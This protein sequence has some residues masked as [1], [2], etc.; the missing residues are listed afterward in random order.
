[1]VDNI[2]I[3]PA[4]GGSKRIPK[5]NIVDF[6]GKPM[7]AWTIEAAKKTGLFKRI[8]VST[9]NEE[10]ADVSV[11]Y[12]AEVPFF[13]DKFS[14]DFTPVSEATIYT[15]NQA[16]LYY[17]ETYKNVFQLMAN[18]PLRTAE[19][20]LS[21][22]NNFNEKNNIFQISCCNFGWLNPWWACSL[23]NDNTPIWLFENKNN[24]R[25]QDL[26][27][28]VCPTGAIWIAKYNELIKEGSFYG[29]NYKMFLMSVVSSVDIDNYDDLNM[30]KAFMISRERLKL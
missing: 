10:I 4:R 29:K 19:D 12:G 25:S 24:K 20:I 13:R 17:N 23:N 2:A 27:K 16:K 22:Y 5:K 21:A 9:D 18:C 26:Q 14:D 7:I 30:A 1:M 3:I 6:L 11:R 15:V 8:I 28:L